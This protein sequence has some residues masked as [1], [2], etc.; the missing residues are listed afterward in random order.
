MADGSRYKMRITTELSFNNLSISPNDYI[1]FN[2]NTPHFKEV[3][4]LTL[5]IRLQESNTHSMWYLPYDAGL[6]AINIFNNGVN[7]INIQRITSGGELRFVNAANH[8]RN[9]LYGAF[10]KIG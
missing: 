7:N 5:L 8:N 10:I 3:C 6:S 1:S 4:T 9:G 2:N